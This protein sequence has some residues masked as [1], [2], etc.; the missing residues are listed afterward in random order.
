[1]TLN[2]FTILIIIAIILAVVALIRPAWP[3]TPIAVLLIGVALL[4][5]R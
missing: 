4:I 2:A 3:L 1:M 5:G